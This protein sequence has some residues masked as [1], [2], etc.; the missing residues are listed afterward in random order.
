MD[1]HPQRPLL[2]IRVPALILGAAGV[3][4]LAASAA[5][6]TA[7]TPH[8][9]NGDFEDGTTGWMGVAGLADISV[10]ASSGGVDGPNAAVV[11]ALAAGPLQLVSDPSLGAP[12]EAGATYEL[13][14]WVGGGE[15]GVSSVNMVIEFLD[16]DGA[17]LG[18]EQ[19]PI[20][21]APPG[22]FVRVALEAMAPVEADRVRVSF[23]AQAESP[24]ASF[25]VDGVRLTLLAP[26][27][28]VTP[29]VQ[30][31]VQPEPSLTPTPGVTATVP[32]ATGTPQPTATVT[33]TPSPT[34][35]P[36]GPTL[37]NATFEDGA[38][39]WNMTGGEVDIDSRGTALLRAP[40]ASTVWMEQPL[41]V[42]P[43]GW[44]Q[45]R[46]LLTPVEGVRAAWVRIAWYAS[47][48][49]SGSQIGT[50]D[51]ASITSQVALADGEAALALVT[52]T[53][54]GVT[55]GAVQ[56]PFAARSAKV[57]VLL[58]PSSASGA[59]LSVSLVAF[60][61]VDAPVPETP[62]A[63]PVATEPPSTTATPA[64]AIPDAGTDA[65]DAPGTPPSSA[66]S[67][68]PSAPASGTTTETAG[69]DGADLAAQR[70][71]RLTEVLPDPVPPGRDAAHEWVEVTNVGSR[72][73]DLVGMLLRDPQRATTLPTLV[74]A[75]GASAVVA[76]PLA[77]VAAD[78]RLDESI[79]N[80]L[81]NEGDRVELVD[82]SGVV[83]DT[84]EYG[85]GT[86][87][88]P[89]TG[90]A[91]HRWFDASG[92]LLGAAVGA[93]SPGEHGP[94]REPV[95]GSGVRADAVEDVEAEDSTG[96]EEADDRSAEDGGDP[97]AWMLLLAI[98][99]G[100]LGGVAV[101]RIGRR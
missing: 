21:L 31:T 55:T 63:T 33:P 34:P 10:D 90:E 30:P 1:G 77:D 42:T 48:D 88:A 35:Q 5:A 11:T 94:V 39:A 66:T 60:E 24:G 98:G 12:I 3:L 72:A 8:V 58:Q 46:A 20:H 4:V 75:P 56:A 65:S 44:Y 38:V 37:R 14:A 91:V 64:V 81:G 40:G 36:I 52:S 16:A 54:S 78:V 95:V 19:E 13:E 80:G 41:T 87:L 43:G 101:Q 89:E 26:P 68:P 22:Q 17:E 53:D 32:P 69:V 49:A 93:P 79:G 62:E 85:T 27:P 74:I 25:V 67:S 18:G 2:R 23:A 50:A 76:G 92:G 57:R 97:M 47:T 59:A 51:S 82:A 70:M 7:Q 86:D 45:A 100:A 96:T 99:G 71:L 61:E 28:P 15:S 9:A 6:Q 73:V 84:V 29:T 83:V